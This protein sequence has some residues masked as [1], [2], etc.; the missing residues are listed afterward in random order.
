[1]AKQNNNIKAMLVYI[2]WNN[3]RV[4]KLCNNHESN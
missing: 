1:M 2:Y 4:L 3:V